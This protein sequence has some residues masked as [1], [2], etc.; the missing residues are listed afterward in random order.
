MGS[1]SLIIKAGTVTARADWLVEKS[2]EE[3]GG[4]DQGQSTNLV[5]SG[6]RRM[7]MSTE[8]PGFVV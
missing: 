3:E 4:G 1:L 2:G 6:A 7:G 5:R 8:C